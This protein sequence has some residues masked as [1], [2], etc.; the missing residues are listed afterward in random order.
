MTEAENRELTALAPLAGKLPPPSD[1]TSGGR[2]SGKPIALANIQL[3]LPEF[4]PRNLPE[5]AEQF[6]EFLLLI[7]LSHVDMATKCL[8]L[9]HSC[10]KNFLQKQ[11]NQIVKTCWTGAQVLQRLEK[12]FPVYEMDLVVRTQR[13]ELPM[14]PEFP[15]TRASLNVC[16]P[17]SICSP[18]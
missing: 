7:G 5:W 4:D 2:K 14:L 8:L 18:G 13:E 3:Q 16:A 9:K 17:W 10:K 15:S 11:G 6:A 1:P 12:T